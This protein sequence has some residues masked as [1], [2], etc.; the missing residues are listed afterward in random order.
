MHTTTKKVAV[1]CALVFLAA[2]AARGLL[3][4]YARHRV[5]AAVDR[6]AASMPG[7]SAVEVGCIRAGFFGGAVKLGELWVRLDT[8]AGPIRIDA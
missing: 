2:A 6:I 7:V 3:Y 5:A 4:G 8:G 1:A